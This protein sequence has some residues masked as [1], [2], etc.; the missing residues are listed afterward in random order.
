MSPAV[1]RRECSVR[2]VKL[3]CHVV[4]AESF[5]EGAVVKMDEESEESK[6]IT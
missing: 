4:A 3:W 5:L 6:G 2:T 1:N